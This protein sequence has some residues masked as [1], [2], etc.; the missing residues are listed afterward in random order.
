MIMDDK[1]IHF[2]TDQQAMC[3]LSLVINLLPSDLYL[4]LTLHLSFIIMNE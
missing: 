1:I 2:M 3:E 4:S